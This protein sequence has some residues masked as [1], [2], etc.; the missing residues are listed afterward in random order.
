MINH[1]TGSSDNL[2]VL[3]VRRAESENW[4]MKINCTTCGAMRFRNEIKRI[5]TERIVDAMYSL[6]EE[7]KDEILKAHGDP[8]GIVERDAGFF[9][10]GRNLW[11]DEMP[12]II[13]QREAIIQATRQLKRERNEER[14]LVEA[15]NKM[16]R[17]KKRAAELSRTQQQR[18]IAA[19]QR[20]ETIQKFSGLNLQD[21]LRMIAEDKERLP[22]YYP[23][24]IENLTAEDL[25]TVSSAVIDQ[26]L[27]R[28]NLLKSDR[29]NS[30]R[31]RLIITIT[32][33]GEVG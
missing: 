25:E 28:L 32:P 21:K 30:V 7:E 26:L 18:R 14:L 1:E 11:K 23:L 33:N 13:L 2:F 6:N 19:Q 4:C 10:Q 9:F 29:W 17:Q 15:T 3:L 22:N 8:I 31:K 27:D 24:Q 12:S 16:E 20:E 5:G